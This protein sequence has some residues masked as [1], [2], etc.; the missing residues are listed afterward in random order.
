M[1]YLG[2]DTMELPDEQ[3][4]P[5]EFVIAPGI[6]DNL[7]MALLNKIKGG[8]IVQVT[9]AAPL[10]GRGFE[11]GERMEVF[12]T[13]GEG[14]ILWQEEGEIDEAGARRYDLYLAIEAGRRVKVEPWK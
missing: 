12:D 14:G 10:S 8:D 2:P 6:P 11:W 3:K 13:D 9:E 1:S 4:S 7:R 5:E